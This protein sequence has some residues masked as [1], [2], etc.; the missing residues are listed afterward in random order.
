M[1][2][3]ILLT[4]AILSFSCSKDDDNSNEEK[5]YVVTEKHTTY[6]KET[7]KTTYYVTLANYGVMEIGK[8]KY[9]GVN[10]NESLCFSP[11]K[12]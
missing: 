9:N 4:V 12:Y 8:E 5:C 11:P 3:L 1:K 2:R 10:V 6:E 7:Q